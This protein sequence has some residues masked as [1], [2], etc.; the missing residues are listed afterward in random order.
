LS[1]NYIMLDWTLWPLGPFRL[2]SIIITSIY[3]VFGSHLEVM[4][5]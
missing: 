4:N 3:V 5:E 1:I 2:W